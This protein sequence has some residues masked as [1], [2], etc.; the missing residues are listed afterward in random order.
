MSK[1]L[2][3]GDRK[4]VRVHIGTN[5]CF[6]EVTDCTSATTNTVDAIR[7]YIQQHDTIRHTCLLAD[8]HQ[9]VYLIDTSQ[10]EP[11]PS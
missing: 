1:M 4:A 5:S 7:E 2:V 9:Q 6:A 3:Q 8:S 10:H 11:P